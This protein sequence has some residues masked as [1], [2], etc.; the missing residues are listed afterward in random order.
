MAV[1]AEMAELVHDHVVGDRERREHESPVERERPCRRA[2][3]PERPLVADPDAAIGDLQPWRFLVR[4]HGDELA[5]GSAGLGLADP[6]GL[7]PEARD[8]AG[9]LLLDPGPVFS[10][11][12][13]DLGASHAAGRGQPRRLAPGHLEPPAPRARRAQYIDRLHGVEP[14]G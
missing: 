5:G 2:R 1:D 4:E 8:L 12:A 7:E 6:E 10:E 13:L 3:A 11:D 14:R 9:A